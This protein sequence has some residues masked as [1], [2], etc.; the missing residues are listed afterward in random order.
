[1]R[2]KNKA[3]ASVLLL[4]F[5]GL[6]LFGGGIYAFFTLKSDPLEELL[7]GDRVINTLFV[8]ERQGKPLSTYVLMYYPNTNRASVFD[9]PGA[10]GLILQKVNRVDRIDSV[11]DP[12]RISDYEQ[13]IEK[14]LGVDISFFY[15]V[16]I[17]NLGKIVDLIEGVEIFIPSRVDIF[18]DEPILFPSGLTRL[19]GDK[20]RVYAT[21]E[22]PEENGELANFR[23]QR[24]FLGLLKRL[25]E[26][27]ETLKNPQVAQIYQSFI[28]TNMRERSRVRL[29]DEFAR[30]DTDRVS[31]QSVG[32]NPREVSGQTLIFPFWNGSLVKDIVRQS[33]AGL[34]R[35]VEGSLSE[36]VF[37][38][39][40]LN[41][42]TVIGLAGRTS[43]LL[44]GF[45]YDIISIGNADSS[46]YE[47]TLIIDRSGFQDMARDFGGIIHCTNIR[48]DALA[49][50]NPE[51]GLDLQNLE[52]KADFTLII[53]RDFNERYVTGN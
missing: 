33:L 42:T 2:K 9:I 36:R 27:N 49:P 26:Q 17:E 25:G 4:I 41:G 35:P 39:E 51:L 21:Y 52:Y 53:G 5:I 24:F 32:G 38:V 6:I 44:Q 16:S 46:D 28:K 40:I 47:R 45:G 29:F 12:R 11:Y 20:A 19:D 30:I 3:D 7:T 22:L 1:M 13:E 50:E 14:L 18:Q 43:E 48:S 15:A 31:I 23:R 34:V 8:I 37:T 10:M